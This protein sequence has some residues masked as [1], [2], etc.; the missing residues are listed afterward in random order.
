MRLHLLSNSEYN[1]N[2]IY[3]RFSQPYCRGLLLSM[4]YLCACHGKQNSHSPQQQKP[5][6]KAVNHDLFLTYTAT[7]LC[8]RGALQVRSSSLTFGA[9]KCKKK[10][11]SQKIGLGGLFLLWNR[12][13]EK[14]EIYWRIITKECCIRPM[15]S[16]KQ[17]NPLQTNKQTKNNPKT[18]T[19]AK[20]GEWDYECQN[21]H[22][23]L[24]NLSGRISDTKHYWLTQLNA[25]VVTYIGAGSAPGQV[26]TWNNLIVIHSRSLSHESMSARSI[27]KQSFGKFISY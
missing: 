7:D 10:G 12:A 1:C 6:N 2:I 25:C 8:P 15:G 3:H 18:S 4:A 24:T 16:R 27:A 19:S 5:V 21:K 14:I 22:L 17:N 23:V 13:A 20:Q 11:R 26:P 9:G